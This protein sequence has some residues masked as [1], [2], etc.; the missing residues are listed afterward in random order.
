[1]P[2]RW[3]ARAL[4]A[5]VVAAGSALSFTTA[6]AQAPQS[7]TPTVV[8]PNPSP[9]AVAT[10]R[11][12]IT[13]KGAN[14]MFDAIVPGVI[15]RTKDTFLPTNPNLNKPLN[16]VAAQLRQEFDA[17]KTELLNEVSRTYARRFTEQELRELL[18]FYKTALGKKVL[19][20]EPLA[21]EESLKRADEW[22][23][24]FSETVINRMRAEMKKKGY[25]L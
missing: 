7:Q 9:T 13:L 5:T 8:N 15:E 14:K 22:A 12:L 17:K 16:E 23:A 21:A 6:R 20:E 18:A 4:L 25:D 11:E 24:T 19:V 10:A 1:M 3:F 2:T